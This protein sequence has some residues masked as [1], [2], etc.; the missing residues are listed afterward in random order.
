MAANNCARRTSRAA[1]PSAK[2]A[3]N[4]EIS[5]KGISG[6]SKQLYNFVYAN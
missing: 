3:E 6:D 2:M 1:K 4:E 5:K